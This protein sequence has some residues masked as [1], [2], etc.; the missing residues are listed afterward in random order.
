MPLV[1]A[2]LSMPVLAM[3]L[4]TAS[5]A[6]VIEH[7]SSDDAYS[8]LGAILASVIVLM[9]AR[10]KNRPFLPSVANFI[11]TSAAGS[12]CPTIGY[13]ILVQW[14][15]ISPEKHLWARTWHAWAAA[16][17]VCGLNGWWLIHRASGL[18][19]SIES[20]AKNRQ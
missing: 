5:A 4:S 6:I 19:K 10:S 7:P 1:T 16:G 13:Y 9:E 20:I 2:A 11:G 12:I 18:L 15:W 8:I 14:G 17:F 3:I